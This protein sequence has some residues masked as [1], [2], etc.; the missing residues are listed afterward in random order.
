M[1]WPRLDQP[2]YSGPLDLL[3]YLV[4]QEEV[5]PTSICLHLVI[6]PYLIAVRALQAI[7]LEETGEFLL[8]AATLVELKSLRLLP[9]K[10]SA[11]KVPESESGS[12]QN[13]VV[14]DSKEELIRQ[15]AEYRRYR[16]VAMA[17]HGMADEQSKR[18]VRRAK[19]KG[20][21]PAHLQPVELWDLV[22]AYAR[23][24][25]ETRTA[26]VERLVVDFVPLPILINEIL[27]ALARKGPITLRDLVG[28]DPPKSRIIGL[29]LAILE[30]LKSG[31][32]LAGQEVLYGDI[33]I[34]QAMEQQSEIISA[35]GA[36]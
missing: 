28:S 7:N 16:A 31:E 34:L 13:V 19:G 15:L 12:V 30:L 4:E 20:D 10:Q 1:P 9:E 33:W 5:D 25:R 8:V 27:E 24:V 11:V 3:L 2:A 36:S 17:L 6:E 18:M 29:F 21:L 32:I 26:S 35:A 14:V 22:S 23:L